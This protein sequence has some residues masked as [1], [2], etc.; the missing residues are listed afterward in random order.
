MQLFISPL[1][2]DLASIDISCENPNPYTLK[3]EP[4]GLAP[5]WVGEDKTEA[6]TVEMPEEI[7][8]PGASGGMAG[9]GIFTV[10]VSVSGASIQSAPALILDILDSEIESYIQFDSTVIIEADILG[11]S[12]TVA[13]LAM[14]EYCGNVVKLTEKQLGDM[15]CGDS[16]DT[17]GTPPPIG[18]TAVL[19]EQTGETLRSGERTRDIVF[20]CG[21]ALCLVL[22]L[23]CLAVP[24][25]CTLRERGACETWSASARVRP[26]ARPSPAPQPSKVGNPQLDLAV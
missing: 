24:L 13:D 2:V 5:F 16:L 18:D 17:L 12:V 10:Q 7:V 1:A 19:S 26:G 3:V 6:G 15:A 14:D 11:F 9:Q 23:F 22:G 4:H 20:D 25:G 8:L 21:F